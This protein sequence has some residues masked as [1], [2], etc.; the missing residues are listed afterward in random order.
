M[1]QSLKVEKMIEKFILN[2]AKPNF[3]LKVMQTTVIHGGA[4]LVDLKSKDLALKTKWLAI[5]NDETDLAILAY[6]NL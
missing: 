3:P 6:N 2:G 1:K 4:G 5:V